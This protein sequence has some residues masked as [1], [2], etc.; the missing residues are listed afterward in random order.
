MNKTDSAGR[1]RLRHGRRATAMSGMVRVPVSK[2]NP[3]PLTLTLSHGEREQAAAGSVLR[4]DSRADTAM[5]CAESQRMIL[6]LPELPEGEGR[7]EGKVD[8]RCANGVSTSPEAS[9]SPERPQCFEPFIL[10]RSLIDYR[11]VFFAKCD[12]IRA[13]KS[14]SD[15]GSRSDGMDSLARSAPSLAPSPAP[16][17]AT[18]RSGL[19]SCMN[20]MSRLLLSSFRTPNFP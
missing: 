6:P 20:T 12:R 5:G 1:I 9:L 4:E 14:P 2:S 18:S 7:G 11:T 3:I 16:I 19:P 8:A 17:S 13:L 10:Q 15:I